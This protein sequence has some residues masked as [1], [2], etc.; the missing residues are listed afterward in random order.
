MGASLAGV[1]AAEAIR[2][3][4]PD[5][6]V[7]LLG[8]EAHAP[9]DRP[10]LSKELL[11]GRREPDELTL[12]D[13]AW[14]EELRIDL[15]TG[16]RAARLHTERAA[17]ELVD[18][19][20]L[21]FDRLLIATGATPR[22][23]PSLDGLAGVHTLRTLDDAIAVRDALAGDG[24]L[25][26][27]GG[28][29]IGLEVAASAR[30]GGAEVTV[31]EALDTV[32]AR[33]VGAEVGGVIERLHRDHGVDVRTGAAVAG[34]VVRGD[35]LCGLELVGGE[36]IDVST[37]VVGIGVV[38]ATDWIAD[39]RIALDDGVLVDATLQ[40]SVPGVFAA[41]DV[42][43]VR[44]IGGDTRRVEHWTTAVEHGRTAGRNMVAE[45][46]ELEPLHEVPTFWSDQYDAKIRAAGT[47]PDPQRIEVVEHR[48][49]PLR[50]VALAPDRDGTLAGI[51][52]IGRASAL[53]RCRPL[54]GLPGSA[55]Q[56]RRL[57][58]G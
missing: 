44:G 33:A 26:V 18:G 57:V 16:V 15:R 2:E 21:A 17:V 4:D 58:A 38:P 20:H 1:A 14:A 51:I 9:Y 47:I 31:L 19:E 12:R 5:V 37:V 40:S 32:L 13:G 7:V 45:P 54:L 48:G 50:L 24:R 30:R 25:A 8:D 53:A 29:F 56:A 55:A 3:R 36:R 49:D 35:R 39:P 10:P 43:R 42:A 46:G 41:G 11:Q 27:V 34:P 6:E 28:G 22:R 23:L 52:T